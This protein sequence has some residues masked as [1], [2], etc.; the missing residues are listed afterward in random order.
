MRKYKK[1]FPFLISCL[2]FVLQACGKHDSPPAALTTRSGAVEKSN[3]KSENTAPVQKEAA[4]DKKAQAY[5]RINNELADFNTPSNAAFARWAAEAREKIEKGDFKAIRGGTS[6]FNDSF[7]RDIKAAMDIPAGMPET[8]AAAKNLLDTV[9]QYLPNWKKL[10][11]YNTAKKFED[12]NGSEGK[13]MLPMYREGIEKLNF[14]LNNFSENVDKIAKEANAKIMARYK[15]DGKLLELYNLEAMAAARSIAD[16]FSELEDFKDQQKLAKANTQ[17]TVMEAKLTE[18]KSEH[19][20]RKAELPK[21][22]PMIDQ[23]DSVYSSLISFGGKYRESRKDPEKF[24]GAIKE[25][26]RA[27]E[28]NNRMMN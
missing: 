5:I 13:R 8:D 20:K 1:F 9:Q 23:Y 26:N 27:I 10:E 11:E 12:D 2:V 4:W 7:V 6:N 21:S 28:S 24:N 3:A 22:L 18:M 25:F 19:E 16:T 14:A 15:S 17:L